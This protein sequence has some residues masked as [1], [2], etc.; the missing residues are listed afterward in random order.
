MMLNTLNIMFNF[1]YCVEM[2]LYLQI[3]ESPAGKTKSLIE[4]FREMDRF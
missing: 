3:G 2:S 1:I 4:A